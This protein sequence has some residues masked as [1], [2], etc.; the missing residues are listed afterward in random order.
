VNLTIVAV[1]AAAGYTDG[2]YFY[3]FFVGPFPLD[4]PALEKGQAPPIG[5]R[6]NFFRAELSQTINTGFRD[7]EKT[8]DRYT[9]QVTSESVS[10]EYIVARVHSKLL[11]LKVPQDKH[12]GT[13][14]GE[15]KPV[16]DDLYNNLI[17]PLT[18]HNMRARDAFLPVF[19]DSTGYRTPGYTTIALASAA[20]AFAIWNMQK[21]F[22]RTR[23][24]REH[25]M[26]RSLARYGDASMVASLID[27]EARINQ[28]ARFQNVRLLPT[29]LASLRT[30]GCEF[31]YITEIVWVYKKA[32][33]HY[34]YFIPLGKTY[35]LIVCD[36]RGWSMRVL[37]SSTAKSVDA[38]A[39]SIARTVPWV[40]LGYSDDLQKLWSQDWSGFVSW[41]AERK[42]ETAFKPGRGPTILTS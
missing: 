25:P 42:K 11:L 41:V 13:F 2:D 14:D 33:R 38:L 26:V 32:T 30:F 34:H 4:V 12:V 1:V 35:S 40:I 18:S 8:V 9:Q 22:R 10:G 39:E 6:G 23:N 24:P 28:P 31:F 16:T 29:W 17:Y 20:M 36:A 7:V 37:D 15:L 21:V 27:N 5:A 19:L 3:N